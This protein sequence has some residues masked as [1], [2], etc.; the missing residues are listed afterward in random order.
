ML[1]VDLAQT[2]M[3]QN[4]I[5]AWLVYDFRGSNPVM[6]QLLGGPKPTTR[7]SFLLIPARG[8]SRLLVHSIDRDLF[9]DAGLLLETFVSW[10]QMQKRLGSTLRGAHRVAME[11]SPLAAL[12]TLSWVDGGTLEMVRSC[13]LEVVSSAPLFQ[14]ALTTW[15]AAGLESHLSACQH[16]AQVKDA[17]FDYIRQRLQAEG[18]PTEYEVQEFIVEEFARRELDMDHRPIVAVNGNSGNPHYEPQAQGSASIQRGDWVLIDLWAR[19]PGEQNV[20]G[21]ITW[22]ASASTKI[23]KQQQRVFSVVK[24]ARDRVVER[25]RLGWGW[26]ETLQGWELDV[27]S[28][29]C[30]EQAGYGDYV[31]HRTGHSLGPGPRVHAL[32]VNLDDLE[33]HDT[34]QVLPGTGF[35]VEPGIYLPDFGV[36][37]EINVYM[38]PERGPLVTTRPQGQIVSLV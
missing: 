3:Q 30:L 35:S 18:S 16:V 7:R 19:H 31:V 1:A 12:P 38:D 36:R 23:S 21:D 15:S 27:V 33:T 37:L 22:V 17:A 6:W 28:R 34:R 14:V 24:E 20:F 29:E 13:G 5:D 26:G 4:D 10:Q 8:E 11:Y 2:Y 9:R 25:L 32:G